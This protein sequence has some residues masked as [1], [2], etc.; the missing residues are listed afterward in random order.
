MAN[1]FAHF[2]P[3]P[4]LRIFL[5]FLLSLSEGDSPP[6]F[7]PLFPFF[8]STVRDQGL[9][10]P[11]SFSPSPSFCRC[12]RDLEELLFRGLPPPFPASF[13]TFLYSSDQDVGGNGPVRRTMIRGRK[14][15]PPSPLLFPLYSS[16]FFL[17]PSLL[18][19]LADDL[20]DH[21][22]RRPFSF[23]S[24]P[25]FSRP[26]FPFLLLFRETVRRAGI[27]AI[28]EEHPFL[29]HGNPP[30]L[31]LFMGELLPSRHRPSLPFF[32]CSFPPPPLFLGDLSPLPFS[33]SGVFLSFFPLPS[34]FSRRTKPEG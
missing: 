7:F 34:P 8:P 19:S 12:G 24:P 15:L 22:A 31:L 18:F 29:S 26:F 32:W 6:P 30:F 11:S 10:P 23:F 3:P 16:F 14:T 2:P 25:S 21:D 33:F 5:L 13:F 27:P 17:S 4:P 1:A 20:A 28:E 9:L